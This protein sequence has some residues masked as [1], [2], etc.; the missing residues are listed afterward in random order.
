MNKKLHI[1]LW[2]WKIMKTTVHQLV[3]LAVWCGVS[4]AHE[5]NGQTVLEKKVSFDARGQRMKKVLSIIEEQADVRFVYS[6]STIDVRQKVD[7]KADN[8]SLEL[9][10]KELLQPNSVAFT[11]S[12]N[13]MIS[14]KRVVSAEITG[15]VLPDVSEDKQNKEVKGRVTDEKGDGLPGVS[16]LVKGTQQGLITNAAGEFSIEVPDESSVLVFSFVGYLSQEV[17]VGNRTSIEISLRADEKALDEV[18][19]VGYGTQKKVNLTGAVDQ[20]A[21]E[22]LENRSMPN[23]TQGLQGMIPNLTIRMMD[24]KPTQSPTYNVRG[25]TSIGQGGSALVLIDGVI[26]DASLLNPNDVATVTVLKDAAAASIYGARGAFG[27]ILITT[28]TPE[29]SGMRVSYSTSFSLKQP[30]SVPQ[31]ENDAYTYTKMFN[32]SWSAWNDYAQTPQNIN[33]TIPFSQAYLAEIER[34]SKDPSLPRTEIGEDGRYVYYHSTDWFEHLY[35]QHSAT[36]EH[37]LSVSGGSD[38]LNFLISGR[39]YKQDGLFRY[40]SDDYKLYNFRAKTAADISSW[41]TLENNTEFA[42]MAYHNPLNVGEQ[43]GIWRNIS[44]EGHPLAPMFNPDGTLTFSAAYTVG[45]FWYGKNGID[46]DSR[47]LRNITSLTSSFLQDKLK[48]KGDLT[49]RYRDDNE[50][51][52]R[53]PVPY[54]RIPGVVEYL[55]TNTNDLQNSYQRNSYIAS[56]I[57]AEYDQTFS[58]VH[59]LKT[60]LGL[61]YENFAFKKNEMFRNGL[62]FEDAEDINLAIGQSISTTGGWEQWAILGGFYRINY[63]FKDRYLLELNGRYDGSS[64]F[65]NHQRFGFFPSFSA[66]WKLENEPFWK[67]P[68]SRVSGLKLRTSYGALGNGNIASYSFLEKFSVGRSVRIIEGALPPITGHP[69]VLPEGLTWEKSATWNFGVDLSLASNRLIANFDRYIRKTVDM[70]TVGRSVP[71]VFGTSVPRGNYADLRTDGWELSLL[72]NDRRSA[73]SKPLGYSVRLFISDNKSEILKYNNP[74]RRL[75]DYYEGQV[76][77]EIWGFETEGLFKSQDEI[78]NHANQSYFFSSNTRS[79]LPGDIKFKDLNGDNTI[80]NGTD[81]VD[82]PGD[83]KIIGNSSPRFAYGVNVGADWNNFFISAFLQGIGKQDWYPHPDAGIFWGQYTRPYGKIPSSQIG[84][85]WSEENPEA[86]F[87]RYRG[88]ISLGGRPLGEN[89]TRYLQNIAYLRMKNIQIGYTIPSGWTSKVYMSNAKIFLSGEN[90]FSWSPLYRV[91]RNLD[92]ENAAN[93]SDAVVT[94]SNYGDGNNYPILKS[95]TLGLTINF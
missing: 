5:T 1:P 4:Y 86:Y 65:P 44:D 56:N 35:K 59:A 34:H 95:F 12:D 17:T 11:V 27:V 46:F 23:I 63:A 61:N 15:N 91:T 33:K 30:T 87:P 80:N 31:Y 48:I 6:P 45:D 57:Y 42:S 7:I 82:D 49:F 28:K 53:V 25:T 94:P 43:G 66:G 64:K 67:I 20:V 41:L 92:A 70:Y 36:K 18:V 37:N 74:E 76:I 50:Q 32:E 47:S 24:G 3:L 93:R 16:I 79:L 84:N 90:L 10:L 40:N 22:V 58:Q 21:S 77:G 89:Q 75:S 83:R 51:R 55:G 9:V 85:I 13:R 29:K 8:K 81:R 19:V 52:R 60:T 73:F 62:L 39:Y 38:K 26:G 88:Y 68:A 54:S 69:N 72:W 78:N 14:L 2:I 71:A